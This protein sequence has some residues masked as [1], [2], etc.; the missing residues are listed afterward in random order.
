MTVI[1]LTGDVPR[2]C[3]SSSCACGR[4]P[5]TATLSLVE[6]SP[7]HLAHLGGRRVAAVH[8][9]GRRRTG[10]RPG[11][12]APPAW[13]P[14]TW[15]PHVVWSV[16]ARWW[17]SWDGR[18]WP[19]TASWWPTPPGVWPRPCPGPA[20]CRPCDGATWPVPSTWASP[21]ACCPAGSPSRPDTSGSRRPGA[22]SPEAHGRSTAGILAAAA[23]DQAA[24]PPVEALVLLGADPVTDFPDRRLAARATESC[25]F[26]LAMASC[27]AGRRRSTTPTFV[28][29]AAEAHEQPGTTTNLEVFFEQS[30]SQQ[31]QDLSVR[32][33]PHEVLTLDVVAAHVALAHH[34]HQV[35]GGGAASP[36]GPL[37]RERHALVA[38]RHLGEAPTVVD[39]ADQVV[40][41]Q[42][43]RVQED[44]VERVVAGHVHDR[45]HR[46]PRR[47]HRAYEVADAALV[48]PLMG[49]AREQYAPRRDVRVT[50]PH[51]L[52]GHDPLVAIAR[53]RGRQGREVAPGVGLAEELAPELLTA[54]QPR[55]PAVLLL[56]RPGVEDRRP[57]PP[58]ADRVDRSGDARARQLVVDDELVRGSAPRPQG[59]GQWGATQPAAARSRPLG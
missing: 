10:R 30:K 22:R 43:H 49:R 47:L 46:D 26:V 58:D 32:P 36:Q 39:L 19:R 50:R 5:S 27:R 18:R 38:E 42:T 51:L 34:V 6:L 20:S 55:Q 59:A 7:V 13:T 8:P 31:P 40:G 4:P 45:P 11:V 57:G 48:R 28:L 2:S 17:W 29:P 53:G 14:T 3:R 15:P 1:L 54:H 33:A 24:G 35:L 44:L 23:G 9:G 25:G 52:A 56:G 37:A 16:P 21:R 12:R 41:G